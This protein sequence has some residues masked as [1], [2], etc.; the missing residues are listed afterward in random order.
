MEIKPGYRDHGPTP[1]SMT[2]LPRGGQ[3]SCGE[4]HPDISGR[5][6]ICT[7]ER[8]HKGLHE[9]GVGTVKLAEWADWGYFEQFEEP[10]VPMPENQ[11]GGRFCA[12]SHIRAGGE[13]IWSCTREKGHD[14]LH[15]AGRP[16][17]NMMA[18]W[19]DPAP[20]EQDFFGSIGL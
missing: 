15:M 10:G 6:W 5:Y 2:S 1:G 13:W 18:Q 11:A 20:V 19:A 9:A 17:G 16:N 14:G 4:T 3:G 8:G 12:A 7:R